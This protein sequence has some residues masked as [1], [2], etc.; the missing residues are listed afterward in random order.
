MYWIKGYLSFFLFVFVYYRCVWWCAGRQ[1]EREREK[2]INKEGK[3]KKGK[4]EEKETKKGWK[5]RD[6]VTERRRE[7]EKE[8]KVWFR[9]HDSGL[10]FF[11]LSSVVCCVIVTIESFCAL[12]PFLWQFLNCFLLLL[13]LFSCCCLFLIGFKQRSTTVTWSYKHVRR[14]KKCRLA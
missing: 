12:P 10:C 1:R 9:Q 4:K 5:E 11:L 14:N 6:K 7:R 8:I 2:T 13:L 3:Q